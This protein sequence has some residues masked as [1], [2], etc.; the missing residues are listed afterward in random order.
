MADSSQEYPTIIGA[1]A[2]F[3]GDLKFESGANIMG[4][5]EGSI[6]SKG[7]V[8]ISDGSECTA[9]ISAKEIA[10]EGRVNGNV[11]AGDR[12][13][14]TPTGVVK[15]DITASRMTMAEGAS[16]D[17]HCRI[18]PNGQNGTAKAR[19]TTE[20]KPEAAAPKAQPIRK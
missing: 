19:S 2:S 17:G 15:G 16:I 13:E 7:R 9:T 10:V 14:L 5:F 20:T 4:R 1:D 8:K 11:Q 3:K 12:I 6:T 18:G